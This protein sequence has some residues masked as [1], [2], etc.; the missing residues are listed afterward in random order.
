M[1]W[2]VRGCGSSKPPLSSIH[3][4]TLSKQFRFT[5]Q[6]ILLYRKRFEHMT[7]TETFS[8][9]QFRE[10]MGLLGLESTSILA[11]RIFAVMNRTGNGRVS[12][13]E[14]LLYMDVLTQGS[15][16]EK[17]ELSYK[18]ITKGL[19][20]P[21]TYEQFAEMILSIWKLY[22]TITGSRVIDSERSIQTIFEQLDLNHDHVVDMREYKHCWRNNK[23]LFEWFEVISGGV[24]SSPQE[25][26]RGNEKEIVLQQLEDLEREVEECLELVDPADISSEPELAVDSADIAGEDD[27]WAAD[28][29]SALPE[30]PLLGSKPVLT[31]S[32]RSIDPATP[33][34]LLT[35]TSDLRTRNISSK[36]HS[37]LS[38][39]EAIRM[40]LQDEEEKAGYLRSFTSP[41]PRLRKSTSSISWGDENWNLIVN[42]ML[43][44]QKAVRSV[45]S[46]DTGLADLPEDCFSQKCKHAVLQLPRGAVNREKIYEFKDYAP[47]IFGQLRLMYGIKP[48]DY[49]KSLGVDK[50]LESWLQ[51]RFSS[52]EGLVSSGKSGSFF[53]YSDDGKYMLKT[54]P[55]EEF[56]LFRRMLKGYFEYLRKFPNSLITRIYGLHKIMSRK[57]LRTTRLYFIVMGNV[58]SKSYEIHSRYDLKGSRIG[59]STEKAEDQDIARKD[60]DFDEI[61]MK[62]QLGTERR[63][64]LISILEE[65]C[66]FLQANNIIDYSVLIGIHGLQG[67]WVQ[68]KREDR[69]FVPFAEENDGG[70][71]STDGTM[72]YFIGI[73][74]VLTFYGGRKKLEHAAKS[75]IYDNDGISCVPPKQYAE[76]FITY[77]TSII[78]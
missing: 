65:D 77:L 30:C 1:A 48:Q 46:V 76:R 17:A 35:E 29:P 42:M 75:M 18:L 74:D 37:V 8:L 15:E 2:C 52:L 45:S 34:I 40:L 73:I 38:K 51:G 54:L 71:I 23:Q 36:L 56:L 58:F 14:Y 55:K 64:Q 43:G 24:T 5:P 69:A 67:F 6:E 3:L 47:A 33:A 63:V 70:L 66:R 72:L 32:R 16:D 53:F 20:E 44:I 28:Y 59:R 10:N 50:M 61:G 9:V 25:E 7:K 49:V 21:I 31:A 39:I 19:L 26:K 27:L 13:D 41:N 78:E 22:N 60:L 68:P 57:K 4:A 11:D 62:I 12:F